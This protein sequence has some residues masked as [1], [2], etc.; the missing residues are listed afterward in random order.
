[1]MVAL[2]MSMVIIIKRSTM[3]MM[4]MWADMG[5]GGGGGG[6]GELIWLDLFVRLR[7]QSNL[8]FRLEKYFESQPRMR[9]I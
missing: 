9:I 1:M 7:F 3:L 2:S 5:G 4:L 8:H 6:G